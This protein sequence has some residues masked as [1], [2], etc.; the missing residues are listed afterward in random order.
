MKKVLLTTLGLM[1]AASLCFAQKP[2]AP[3][4]TAL[5]ATA[6]AKTLNGVVDAVAMADTSKGTKPKIS[7]IDQKGNIVALMVTETTTIAGTDMKPT[8]LD[9]I[10]KGANVEAEYT[11]TKNGIN[12]ASEISLVGKEAKAS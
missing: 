4:S 6:T 1:V 9:K 12:I 8:T 7:I 10:A 11:T 5:K 2:V 3:T